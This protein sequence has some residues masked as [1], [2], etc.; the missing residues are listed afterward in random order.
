MSRRKKSRSQYLNPE[1]EAVQ[2]ALKGEKVNFVNH[3]AGGMGMGN[4][5]V[6]YSSGCS[7]K[8]EQV[9]FEADG[10]KLYGSSWQG[11][12]EYS[13]KWDLII[14]LA[15]NV[16]PRYVPPPFVRANSADRWK[17]LNA[18]AESPDTKT[19]SAELLS[20]TWPDMSAP[21]ATL[22]FW[23]ALWSRLP[24]KTVIACVGGHGRTGTALVSLMI[25]SGIDYYTALETV[26]KD[27]CKKAVETFAQEQYLHQLYIDYLQIMIDE[28]EQSIQ[29]RFDL[30]EELKYA[31]DHPPKQ[32]D[33]RGYALLH[34]SVASGPVHSSW[35]QSGKSDV[36]FPTTTK[37]QGTSL[38]TQIL[39]GDE[40]D[41]KRREITINNVPYVKE[42][43]D[44]N[45]ANL[46]CTLLSHQGWM[47]DFTKVQG[48]HPKMSL[49]D[50][51]WGV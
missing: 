5:G 9:V 12:N 7:H 37:I 18:F 17:D 22:Q 43:I 10:K 4:G 36:G 15:D 13:K 47:P 2:T 38:Q 16:V 41:P 44:P 26:R 40:A 46:T 32:G 51:N 24:E 11:L 21:R 19:I 33:E 25:A 27:H 14:D 8:G 49:E 31:I 30:E 3:H 42:C 29:T 1:F 48:E 50:L 6:I 20:L 23:F 39:Y 45:C 35:S 34:Q 28:P